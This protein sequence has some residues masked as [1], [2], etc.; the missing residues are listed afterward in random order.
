MKQIFTFA[1]LFISILS[2]KAQQTVSL[3]DGDPSFPEGTYYKDLNNDLDKFVG[4]WKYQQANTLLTLVLQKKEHVLNPTFS[5]YEDLIIGEYKYE[6]NGQ[7]ILNYLPRLQDSSVTGDFHYISGNIILHSTDIPK[8][9]ECHPFERRIRVNF[10]DPE[11]EYIPTAMIL[12]HQ[13]I[14]GVEQLTAN[15]MGIGLIVVTED[16]LPEDTRVPAGQYILIKQ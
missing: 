3:D 2:C 12:R 10:R 7:E 6:V 14:N 4:V 9:L 16:G 11:R 13:I 8:C 15:L 5:I 1:F